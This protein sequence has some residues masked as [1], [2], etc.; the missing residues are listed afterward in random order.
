MTTS[1]TKYYV[2]TAGQQRISQHQLRERLD[3]LLRVECP[4]LM[5]QS[6]AAAGDADFTLE[7][8]GTGEV[9]RAS[10]DRGTGDARVDDIFGGLVAELRFDPPAAA[11]PVARARMNVGY[12]CSPTAAVSTV[13]LTP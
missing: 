4:R 8:A 13:E 2:P 5:G 9:A 3:A 10:L 6:R 7:V 12:S 1:T 11:A